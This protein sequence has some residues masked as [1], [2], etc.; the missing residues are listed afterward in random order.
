MIEYTRCTVGRK[1]RWRFRW[2]GSEV[3]QLTRN[4]QAV[5]SIPTTS[6]KNPLF[7]RKQ[8]VFCMQKGKKLAAANV[9]LGSIPA[10]VSGVQLE[11]TGGILRVDTRTDTPSATATWKW[12]AK[13]WASLEGY[14][15]TPPDRSAREGRTFPKRISKTQ[16]NAKLRLHE[17]CRE[18]VVSRTQGQSSVFNVRF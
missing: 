12:T 5:G 4:E 6:S 10:A 8:R 2:C 11:Q 17:A 3:E 14:T 1:A 13:S 16:K 18:E 15:H 7:S 9:C